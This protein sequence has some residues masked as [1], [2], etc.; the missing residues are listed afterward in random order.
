MTAYEAPGLIRDAV[1]AL[2]RGEGG[3]MVTRELPGGV[4][5]ITITEPESL[6]AVRAAQ[7]LAWAARDWVR[8]YVRNA[9]EDGRGWAEIG[10][11]LGGTPD[12]D[13]GITVAAAAFYEVASDIGGGPSF[14]W[15][16]PSCRKTVID[17]GPETGHPA[18]AERGHAEGCGRFAATVAAWE[19][20]WADE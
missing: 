9:R 10:E 14:G 11:A 13:R 16:C 1:I 17:Y 12:P 8:R 20:Q 3:A 7:R 5:G 18:D 4:P 6:A 19:E 15:T 2:V